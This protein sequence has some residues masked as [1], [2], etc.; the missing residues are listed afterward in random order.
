MSVSVLSVLVSVLVSLPT[1]VPALMNFPDTSNTVTLSLLSQMLR[2]KLTVASTKIL[3]TTGSFILFPSNPSYF[4]STIGGAF[5]GL[6]DSCWEGKLVGIKDGD[7]EKKLDGSTDSMAVR[8]EDGAATG[9]GPFF[10]FGLLFWGAFGDLK[11]LDLDL[12]VL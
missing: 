11:D 9:R 2:K 10:P 12:L 1:T 3:A 4:I 5:D 6:E 7:K 8:M